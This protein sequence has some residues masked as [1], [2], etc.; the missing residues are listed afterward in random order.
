MSFRFFDEI[1][2]YA[3]YFSF[4]SN[5]SSTVPRNNIYRERERER[6]RE[7]GR[8]GEREREREKD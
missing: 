5:V 8:E 6:E 7:G 4:Y 1:A 2:L 3:L